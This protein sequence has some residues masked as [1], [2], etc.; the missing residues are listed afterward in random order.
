MLFLTLLI[1]FVSLSI[2]YQSNSVRKVQQIIQ[3]YDLFNSL[4]ST[5]STGLFA[6]NRIKSFNNYGFDSSNYEFNSKLFRSKRKR[7][8]SGLFVS[9]NI[10]SSIDSIQPTLKS[11]VLKIVKSIHST[12]NFIKS[13]IFEW[14]SYFQSKFKGFWQFLSKTSGDKGTTTLSVVH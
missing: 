4:Q 10:K 12:F 1:Q 8:N 7:S 13:I 11:F 3:K 5:I 14:I 9:S 2:A 6:M